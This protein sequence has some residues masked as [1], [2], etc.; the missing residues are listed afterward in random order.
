MGILGIREV[1]DCFLLFLLCLVVILETTGTF[2]RSKHTRN[3]PGSGKPPV[4]LRIRAL[5]DIGF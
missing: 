1:R 3:S 5:E 2:T 4:S